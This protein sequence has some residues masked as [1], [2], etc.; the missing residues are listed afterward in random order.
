LRALL[1]PVVAVGLTGQPAAAST[2]VNQ[3]GPAVAATAAQ[4]RTGD[5]RAAASAYL[6]A[7]SLRTEGTIVDKADGSSSDVQM[8]FVRPD[9]TRVRVSTAGETVELVV[10]GNEV[11]ENLTGTWQKADDVVASAFHLERDDPL[12]TSLAAGELT[13]MELGTADSRGTACRRW[14]IT[15]PVDQVADAE[16]PRTTTWCVSTADDTL[17]EQVMETPST[18]TTI[19]FTAWN[20]PITIEKPA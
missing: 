13:V 18:R 15:L 12:M 5:Y 9:R 2:G 1:V 16:A 17:I 11:F 20:A 4:A 3:T 14:E 7:R 8:E 6:A 19:Y 10:V